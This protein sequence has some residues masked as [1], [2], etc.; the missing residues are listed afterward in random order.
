MLTAS[1]II[2][3][4]DGSA[5]VARETGF[6]LTTIESWKTA[7]F[8]PDWRHEAILKL[9]KRKKVALA[10]SDFPPKEARISRPEKAA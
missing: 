1:D 10:A 3:R 8:I 6:P 4:L 7:N 9:A 2:E 5:V